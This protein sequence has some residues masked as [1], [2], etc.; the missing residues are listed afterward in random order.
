M[1]PVSHHGPAR[2]TGHLCLPVVLESFAR[3]T[4]S[5]RPALVFRGRATSF[6]DLDERV[7]R[8]AAA[9]QGLGVGHGDRVAVLM[10]NRPQ[11]VETWFAVQRLGAI[12]VPV[13]TRFV[14]REVA[15]VLADSGAAVLAVD[16]SLADHGITACAQV[17][18]APRILCAT[19]HPDDEV[20]VGTVH[21]ER[22]MQRA[23]PGPAP[24]EVSEHDP[25][26][27]MYT[28]G[29][30]GRPKGA[31]L[32][33]LG[34]F[35]TTVNT[36]D[37]RRP[38][39]EDRTLV[40]VPL[41]HIAAVNSVVNALL[42]GGCALIAE[43][44]P[45][46]P[47]S[48]ADTLERDRITAC[49]MVPTQWQLLCD[50]PGI[51]ERDIPLRYITWGA[52]PASRETLRA[53]YATFPEAQVLSAF[54]QT[55]TCGSTTM[56]RGE[57]ALRKIGS[58]GRPLRFVEA[59]IVDDTMRDVPTGAVGEIVY[60]GPTVMRGYWN[61]PEATAEAFHGGWFHSGDL[62]REDADGFVYVVD[63]KK[64]MIVSGGEN[65]YPAELEAVLAEHPGVREAAVVG[66]PDPVWGETPVAYVVA[67][68]DGGSGAGGDAPPSAGEL[69]DLCRENLASYKKPREVVFLDALPR[70]ASGKV[71][72]FRL[73]DR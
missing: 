16:P 5:E 70:T 8:L 61:A 72:K 58:V 7:N 64:D 34:L 48:T 36:G 56:L 10:Q 33:H 29:T 43:P 47:A 32:T 45:F 1:T 69:V 6:R 24:V 49:F 25:A 44:G 27:L 40:S 4:S 41:F 13:N 23:G 63:R 62:C 30:T 26:F 55:E 28:S 11:V 3:R 9:L 21:M 2:A 51:R 38:L 37:E 20:P 54:G 19:D 35:M 60:R 66:V 22:A 12:A 42:T 71:Q 18:T 14:V 17:V 67:G 73:R 39:P 68:A 59:R 46:D 53:L 52:A 15:H 65:I 31:V 50:L 57:D